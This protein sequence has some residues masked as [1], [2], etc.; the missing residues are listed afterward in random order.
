MDS[1]KLNEILSS[2]F[3]KFDTPGGFS[4]IYKLY[5]QAKKVIPDLSK[6]SVIDWLRAQDTYGVHLP[7]KSRIERSR[8]IVK[9]IDYMWEM[10][11]M[12]MNKLRKYNKDVRYVLLVIDVFSKYVW[13]KGMKSKDAA[14]IITFFKD[15]MKHSNRK[16]KYVRTDKGREFV[17]ANFKEFV[18]G[19]GIE[20]IQTQSEIKAA[21]AERA[22]KTIKGKLFKY[23]Y[24]KQVYKYID[25]LQSIAA[26]YNSTK[27]STIKVA[28]DEV[29]NEN[30]TEI[31]RNVYT[32]LSGK[33]LVVRGLK[34]LSLLKEGDYVRISF[35]RGT[36]AREYR[37]KWSSE[38]FQIFRRGMRDGIV[39]Y[40][41]RDLS[42]DEVLGS[43]YREEIEPVKYSL[44]N[45]YKIEKILRRKHD[46]AGKLMYYVKW[47]NWDKKFNS[48][49]S[50]DQAEE[51]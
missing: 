37:Q 44:D 36:F 41:L 18:R 51:L 39:V 2:I 47:L 29:S 40:W 38:V 43:F 21:V 15:I 33:N 42:G 48:W 30:E 32:A 4:S 20:H 24:H 50:R 46:K 5:N 14:Q 17:N 3:Y 12:D 13:V 6:K 7:F 9:G 28:P 31:W 10:D 8:I 19:E 16:P 11:L 25:V 27:H 1:S 45:I 49:I 35:L 34:R 22:I 23:M 26:Q